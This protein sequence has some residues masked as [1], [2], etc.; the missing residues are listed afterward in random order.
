M[1]NQTC[2]LNPSLKKKHVFSIDD[3]TRVKL[4]NVD[5]DPCSDYINASYTPVSSAFIFQNTDLPQL[6]LLL[7]KHHIVKVCGHQFKILSADVFFFYQRILL[8]L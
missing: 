5:D 2:A 4:S 8:M 7:S 3:F 1:A 6:I